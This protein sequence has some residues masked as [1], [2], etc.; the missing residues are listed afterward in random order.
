MK[1]NKALLTTVGLLVAAGLTFAFLPG[2]TA[3]ETLKRTQH[4]TKLVGG[5]QLGPR[6]SSLSSWRG[7]RQTCLV[8]RAGLFSL[9]GRGCLGVWWLRSRRL[10]GLRQ[11]RRQ[12]QEVKK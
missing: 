8:E 1:G 9:V 3:S 10:R 4:Y 7:S 12:P 11:L 5:V 2:E 6:T